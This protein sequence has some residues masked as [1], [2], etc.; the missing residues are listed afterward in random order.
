M[1]SLCSE[2]DLGGLLPG[3]N[4][5]EGGLVEGFGECS[6]PAGMTSR[7]T[8]YLKKRAEIKLQLNTNSEREQE[9]K[10]VFVRF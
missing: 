10:T 8:D 6:G 5:E 3:V 2:G 1:R 9:I 4:R 7:T